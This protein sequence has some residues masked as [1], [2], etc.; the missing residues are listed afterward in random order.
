MNSRNN[1]IKKKG[2]RLSLRIVLLSIIFVLILLG[3]GYKYYEWQVVKNLSDLYNSSWK[4][5]LKA[6]E[7]SVKAGD[8]FFQFQEDTFAAKDFT[9]S[10]TKNYDD[11]R[12]KFNL[13]IESEEGY[14]NLINQNR[15]KYLVLK[16]SSSFLFG[17]Q[18]DFVR[19]VVDLQLKYYD[20]EIENTNR[21]VAGS[22]LLSNLLS[23]LY[24]KGIVDAYEKKIGTT[25]ANIP[26][27]FSDISTIQSYTK[28]D[29]KF[30]HEDE[31]KKYFPGG[32]ESLQKYRDY[33]STYY[34]VVQDIVN[35]DYQSAAYKYTNISNN[36]ASLTINFKDFFNTQA[37]DQTTNRDKEI[38][39]IVSNQANLIK[40]FK[41]NGLG[42]YP[43]LPTINKWEEDLVLC[44][45]YDFKAVSV[46]NSVTLKYPA[47]RNFDDLL[48]EL[49]GVN[50]RTDFVDSS[51]DKS[52][53]VFTNDDKKI[54][55]QCKDKYDGDILTFTTK[56]S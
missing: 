33:L 52:V 50:P 46:Y 34:L 48:K 37:D 19:K 23:V 13:Y 15:N 18:G 55:F 39:D 36:I 32:Y 24:D 35:G 53:V 4:Q 25:Y 41:K 38:V 26:K 8:D 28:N 6:V 14:K 44:K 10:F 7:N 17:P 12:G 56:K 1:L 31:I 49:S 27:Y 2:V 43:L 45:M 21:N 29:F 20:D 16:S 47:S 40:Q 9:A 51:F 5:E 30:S 3:I 54:E 22:Y 42:K 11:L